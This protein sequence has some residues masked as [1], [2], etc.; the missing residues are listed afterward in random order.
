M[1]LCDLGALSIDVGGHEQAPP[2]KRPAAILA[3]LLIHANQRVSVETVVDT[4]WGEHASTRSAATLE[5]HIWRLRRVLEPNRTA[6]SPAGVL[7][8]QA[9]GYRLLVTPEQADSLHFSQLADEIADLMTTNQPDRALRRCDEALSLWRG[10]PYGPM[11]DEE[12]ALAAVARLEEQRR[13]IQERRIDALLALRQAKQALTDVEALIRDMPYNEH[14]RS[15]HMLALY[16]CGRADD[17]LRAYRD[18]R[19]VLLD[20]IGL[21]PGAEMQDLQRRILERDPSLEPAPS[22]TLLPVTSEVHLPGRTSEILGREGELAELADLLATQR[23][24]TLLGPAGAGKTRL[25]IEVA[26]RNG[27]SFRDGVWF[28]DLAAIT[29]PVL[30][31]PTLMATLGLQAPPVGSQL[32]ALSAHLHGR[33]ALLVLDNC[34]H[35]MPAISDVASTLAGSDGEVTILAT[36]REPLGLSGERLVIVDPLPV[37]ASN[38]PGEPAPAITLFLQRAREVASE[39]LAG[40]AP[41]TVTALAGRICAAVD[42]LPLAI[43]LAAARMQTYTLEEIADQVGTDPTRLSR[44]TSRTGERGSSLRAALDWSDRLLSEPERQ[45]HRNLAILPGPFTASAAAGVWT[46]LIGQRRRAEPTWRQPI[47]C[48]C[49]SSAPCW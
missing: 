45:L 47:C 10:R 35:L 49:W 11:A 4:V 8:N 42:G 23:L 7:V 36:S 27:S 22:E 13:Q 44:P 32:D 31:V 24:I 39:R 15:Q 25:G 19:D 30:I 20:D 5:T 12:W 9:G 26:S 17:A 48:H 29:D 38:D 34:E 6:G 16:Q 1:R 41:E 37:Q 40:L 18:A 14:T 43:E 33:A 2:G 46:L 28:A 21:E 3:L